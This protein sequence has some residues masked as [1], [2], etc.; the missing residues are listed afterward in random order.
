M[1]LEGV[2]FGF[3]HAKRPTRLPVKMWRSEEDTNANLRA[4][5]D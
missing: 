4:V 3:M 5:L 1:A 2:K